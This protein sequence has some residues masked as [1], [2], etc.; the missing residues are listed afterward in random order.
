LV[1]VLQDAC[2]V[3][4]HAHDETKRIANTAALLNQHVNSRALK[5]RCTKGKERRISRWEHEAVLENSA[6]EARWVADENA[7]SPPDRR[8]SIRYDKVV[9]TH[10]QMKTLKRVGWRDTS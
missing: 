1:V 7:P 4:V 10:F 9:S 2:S 8:A 6:S 5:G 3:L